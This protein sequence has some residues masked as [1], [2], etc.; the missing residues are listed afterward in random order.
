M[1]RPQATDY[2]EYY[3]L[4]VDQVPEGNILELLSRGI[5][6]TRALLDGVPTEWESFR[7]APGK[8]SVREVV[9][10]MIDA[11]RV[12]GYRALSIARGDA[13]PLPGMDQDQ[14]ARDSNAARRLLAEQLEEFE[15]LRRAHVAMFAGFEDAAWQRRGVASGCEFGVRA[16]PYILAGHENHHR[17]VLEERYLEPLQQR[18]AR[19]TPDRDAS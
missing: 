5:D 11:E 12:F 16:F 10:H 18:A 17:R 7:Y 9:G 4:Y 14:W 2:A 19:V 3:G 15:L 13:A 1:E 6:E 8:W